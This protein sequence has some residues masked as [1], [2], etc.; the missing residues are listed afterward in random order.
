M[1]N[2]TRYTTKVHI[3]S[4]S[5][6]S[7][8]ERRPRRQYYTGTTPSSPQTR[9]NFVPIGRSN[10]SFSLRRF[11]CRV[12]CNKPLYSACRPIQSQSD[13]QSVMHPDAATASLFLL[14]LLLL[15]LPAAGRQLNVVCNESYR[16]HRVSNID[17]VTLLGS[18][19]F[20]TLIRIFVLILSR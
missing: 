6:I 2:L 7:Q 1:S 16:S 13:R 20:T 5:A 9:T 3:E 14:L 15:L 4:V 17:L 12:E 10:D 18:L 8:S 19:A 11:A